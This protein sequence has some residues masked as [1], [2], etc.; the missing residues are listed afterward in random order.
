M[1]VAV[2]ARR[3]PRARSVINAALDLG[4]PYLLDLGDYKLD[5]SPYIHAVELD[6]ELEVPPTAL[7]LPLAEDPYKP[8]L[9]ADL[10]NVNKVILPPP[11]A[12]DELVKTYETA[13]EHGVEVVW[14]YGRPPLARPGD[15]E[16][17][18]EAVHPKAARII[19]DVVTAKSNREIIKTL[20]SLQGYIKYMYLSNRRGARGP[21]L[22]PFDPSG[23][24]NYSDVVQ[25]AL[26]LQWDGQYVLRAAPQYADKISLQAAILNEIGETYRNT[27]RA[28]KKVQKM[29]AE[30][31][32]ELF[33]GS[34]LE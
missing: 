27:G 18:A 16:A 28:S 6:L 25:A 4:L 12:M 13:V 34:G 21:R 32:N 19:Y 31:L 11:A 33:A 26:L 1:D 15:V 7:V 30:V 10:L 9:V 14:L 29:V 24:I 3:G 5:K 23:V 17:V 22:P 8:V 2:Y 20:V